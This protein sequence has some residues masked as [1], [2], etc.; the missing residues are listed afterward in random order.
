M[1]AAHGEKKGKG[2]ARRQVPSQLRARRLLV[3][4]TAAEVAERAG[5]SRRTLTN[6]EL[7]RARPQ[8]RTALAIARALGVD[9]DVR[10]LFPDFPSHRSQVPSSGSRS[11]NVSESKLRELHAAALAGQNGFLADELERLADQA[12]WKGESL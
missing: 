9:Q 3:G 4:L 7:G 1:G 10:V 12:M 5:I 6:L 2:Q 8:P 11:V